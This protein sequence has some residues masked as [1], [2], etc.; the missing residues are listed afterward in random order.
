MHRQLNWNLFYRKDIAELEKV[1]KRALK[2]SI[3]PI[4]SVPLEQRWT[5]HLHE[6]IEVSS[7]QLKETIQLLLF[8]DHLHLVEDFVI[9]GVIFGSRTE[10]RN[11][12]VRFSGVGWCRKGRHLNRPQHFLKTL[13]PE[14]VDKIRETRDQYVHA[15]YAMYFLDY[16]PDRA[17]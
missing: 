13:V 7:H 17:T 11:V 9:F 8:N 5:E 10:R 6:E 16:P 15:W 3:T 12:V 14:L 4:K 2:L 1:Q